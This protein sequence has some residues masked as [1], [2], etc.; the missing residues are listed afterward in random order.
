MV[1]NY[2]VLGKALLAK[3]YKFLLTDLCK[4]LLSDL[5]KFDVGC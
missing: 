5:C 3:S 1:F 2:F 4:S